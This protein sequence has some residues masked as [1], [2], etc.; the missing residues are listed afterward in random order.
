MPDIIV[1]ITD[2]EV[3]LLE[4]YFTTAGDGVLAVARKGLKNVAAKIINEST[5]KLAPNKLSNSELRAEIARL[6]AAGEIPT[7]AERTGG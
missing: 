4:S 1:T 2:E 5:S 7:H 6:D 3:T